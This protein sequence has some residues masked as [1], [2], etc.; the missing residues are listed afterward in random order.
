MYII[1]MCVYMHAYAFAKTFTFNTDVAAGID[2]A[3]VDVSTL[4]YH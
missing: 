2:A 1:C 3:A 4:L